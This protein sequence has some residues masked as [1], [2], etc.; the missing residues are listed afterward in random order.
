MN[1]FSIAYNNF[2]HNMK[3]YAL[4]L[5]A[6]IFSVVVYYNFIALK[7]ND[8]IGSLSEA[9][10]D[11]S[12]AAQSTAG[13]LLVFLIFFIWYSSSFFLKQKK[14]EIGVY[15]FMGVDNSKIGFIYAI[16]GIFMGITAIVLGLLIGVLFSKLFTMIF[17]KIAYLDVKIDFFIP[18]KGLIETAVTFFIIFLITS[19]L[20][21]FNIVRSKL[22]DLFNASKKYEGIPKISYFKAVASISITLAVYYVCLCSEDVIPVFTKIPAA[23][24]LTIWGT[25][26][27]FGSFFSMVMKYFINKKR[28]LYKGVNVVSMSNITFRIKG[29]YKALATIAILITATI[30]AFGTAAAIKYSFGNSKALDLPYSFTYVQEGNGDSALEEKVVKTIKESKHNI[31]L[32]EK[33]NYLCIDKF[34]SNYNLGLKDVIAIKVSDFKRITRDLKIKNSEEII[35]KLELREGETI[36]VERPRV[37]AAARSSNGERNIEMSNLSFRVKSELKTPLFGGGVDEG[38]FIVNDSDYGRLK[39]SYKEYKFDGIIVN[40][41]ENSLELAKKLY[42]IEPL[43]KSLYMY[44]AKYKSG[45]E[46]YGIIFFMGSFLT[47]VFIIATGSIIHFKALS[48]AY[49][50]KE[51]YQ[52]LIKLGI[53][54]EELKKSISKQVSVFFIL[55]LIVGAIHSSFAISVLSKMMK[56]SLISPTAISIAILSV[57]YLMFYIFTVRKFVKVIC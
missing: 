55:P 39:Q 5:V 56:C 24:A 17:V 35:K 16:E 10:R 1:S 25:Y 33:A 32:E 44:I 9:M 41:Q 23:T 26:W 12:V 19:I 18:V 31:L 22:I 43:R 13:L 54:E 50:D 7:Y 38:C 36:Y 42:N 52:V 47:L 40:N 53:T 3:T 57:V 11:V 6:M 21:Y 45:Y 4:H 29:N 14:K 46:P 30:T 34:K 15:A 27:L 49:M 48:E 51:K 37:M 8:K 2:K 20:G 28:V